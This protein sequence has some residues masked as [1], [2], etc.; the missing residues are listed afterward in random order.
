[1]KMQNTPESN[2][3]LESS[4]GQHG[5][6][7]SDSGYSGFFQ[8]P[9][10]I[11]KLDST[12]SLSSGEYNEMSKENQ[13]LTPTAKEKT[14]EPL[15]FLAKDYRANQQP[16]L[17]GWTETPK[18][19]SSLHQRLQMCRPLAAVKVE[20][21]R[22]P[23]TGAAVGTEGTRSP[24]TVRSKSSI[25]VCAEHWISTSFDSLDALTGSFVSD[26][27]KLEPDVPQMAR[28]RCLF[29]QMRTSTREDG[30]RIP[31]IPGRAISLLGADVSLSGCEQVTAES[32][33]CMNVLESSTKEL[34]QSPIIKNDQSDVLSTPASTQTPKYVRYVP[35]L[36]SFNENCHLRHWCE[37]KSLR[38][39]RSCNI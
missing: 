22:L 25:G 3:F 28:K 1:M 34:S 14:K 38:I 8:S 29:A 33:V 4:K 19:Q 39:L 20:G 31:S 16:S 9:Q 37:C 12:K 10:D 30:K 23:C 5:Y 35:S 32:P 7:C 26:A 36:I 15:R 24:R 13:R 2:A 21:S 6:D 11:S 18:R 17:L 27:L